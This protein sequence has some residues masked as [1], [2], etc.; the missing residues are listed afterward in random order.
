MGAR[1][2]H[3]DFETAERVA[4]AAFGH[5][6][7]H[8][9]L[10]LIRDAYVSEEVEYVTR[11]GTFHGHD[12][13]MDD[14]AVQEGN[15]DFENEVEEVIDAGEGA[16][17]LFNKVLR[18]DKESGAVVWKAWPA[19]VARILDGKFVFFEGYI[20]RRQALADYGVEQG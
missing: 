16:I 10:E 9:D 3:D 1:G 20:D 13:W 2:P 17:I 5:Y 6:S 15:F 14:F 12:R 8:Q 19:V 18:K 7:E 11:Q 4:R